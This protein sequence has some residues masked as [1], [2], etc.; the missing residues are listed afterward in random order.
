MGYSRLE[1][2]DDP[3][4]GR[5][6]AAAGETRKGGA[7]IARITGARYAKARTWV[8]KYLT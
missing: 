8:Q 7:Y 3:F 1:I 6:L 2:R 4:E 5:S